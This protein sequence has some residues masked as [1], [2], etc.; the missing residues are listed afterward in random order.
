MDDAL[1]HDLAQYGEYLRGHPE[2]QKA[3]IGDALV[4]ELLSRVAATAHEPL[5]QSVL[6]FVAGYMLAKWKMSHDV[7]NISGMEDFV[8]RF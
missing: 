3:L 6:A 8:G 7:P 4:D 5:G 1:A 2:L